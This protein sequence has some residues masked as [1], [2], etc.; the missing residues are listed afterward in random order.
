MG[1]RQSVVQTES[2]P[3][4]QCVPHSPLGLFYFTRLFRYCWLAFFFLASFSELDLPSS[5][6]Y[7]ACVCA[8][9]V[10]RLRRLDMAAASM[11]APMNVLQFVALKL[12]VRDPMQLQVCAYVC[13]SCM[14]MIVHALRLSCAIRFTLH[15]P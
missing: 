5:H 14:G 8:W 13:M 7:C 11:L 4:L 1:H 10:P 3:M 2:G 6:A 15:A 9:V 12:R